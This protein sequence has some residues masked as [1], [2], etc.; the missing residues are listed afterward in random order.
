M[1][2]PII[3]E[4]SAAESRKPGLLI[5]CVVLGGLHELEVLMWSHMS[6]P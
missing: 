6:M 1:E 4:Q 2:V 5:L 3:V